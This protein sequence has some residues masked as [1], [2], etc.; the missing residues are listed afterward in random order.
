MLIK[1]LHFYLWFFFCMTVL[2]SCSK[3][4]DPDPDPG[5]DPHVVPDPPPHGSVAE[6]TVLIYIGGD[7]ELDTK[8]LPAA[9]L[10]EMKEAIKTMDANLYSHNNLLVFYDQY[11]ETLRPKLYRLI[12]KG[13]VEPSKTDPS[14]KELVITTEE[15]LI[16]EYSHEITF[17]N[18]S[19]LKEV[20]DM[21]FDEFPAKS[22]GFVYWS[23][24]EGW[25][26]AKSK[27]MAIR[28][29][30][31]FR[32]MGFDK[33]NRSDNFKSEITELADALKQAP[34]KFDFILFD[35]CFMLSLESSYELRDCADYIISSP[36]ETPGP[37]APY[38]DVVPMMFS[39]SQAAIKMAEAYFK[40]YND[41][42]NPNVRTTNS[43]WTGGVSLGVLDC[44]KLAKLADVTKANLSTSSNLNSLL[45][46]VFDYDKRPNSHVGYYDMVQLMEKVLKP[47]GVEEWM[48]AFNDALPYWKTTPKNYSSLIGMFSMEGTHG[49]SHYIPS[50]GSTAITDADFQK[51]A[52]Y[53][54]AG[55]SQLGW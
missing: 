32:W 38:S 14:K 33:N 22:Y 54:D 5:P 30:T 28:S 53:K 13:K 24:G 31:P 6:R 50:G 51:T 55:L 45:N 18:P 29:L 41:K 4:N 34:K 52:W 44:T 49:V 26:P 16:Y 39:S 35:A 40:Y 20:M 21:A 8:G 3:D 27:I 12:K 1:N 17:T 47:T 10:D 48:K 42:Y 7:N 43:N 15:E 2:V 25:L 9:D 36:T 37:G 46:E 19:V 11:S 23:H